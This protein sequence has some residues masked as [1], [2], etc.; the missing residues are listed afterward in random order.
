ESIP[1]FKAVKS[2]RFLSS[3]YNSLAIIDKE[4]GDY[5]NAIINHQK[6]LKYRRR[7]SNK[8]F[9]AASINNIGVVYREQDKY[10][11]A[12]LY[13]NQ[14]LS[15]DSLYDKDPELFAMVL[16]NQGYANHKLG[17]DKY[18]PKQFFR[19]LEIKDSINDIVGI[20]TGKTT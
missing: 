5:E 12:L 14:A 17:I 18:L 8:M 19:S 3:A 7:L 1:Y 11:E 10:Q 4:L 6:A 2:D 15:Y 16:N 20:V 9:E 13:F